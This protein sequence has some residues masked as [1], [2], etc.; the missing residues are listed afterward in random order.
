MRGR[1]PTHSVDVSHTRRRLAKFGGAC[2]PEG[3]AMTHGSRMA[4]CTA[5]PPCCDAS[6]LRSV[7]VYDQRARPRL[8]WAFRK[9]GTEEWPVRNNT[10]LFAFER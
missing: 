5:P 10:R 6:C 4:P 3:R 8:V 9:R 2:E 7:E 1:P